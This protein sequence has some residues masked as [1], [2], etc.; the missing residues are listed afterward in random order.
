MNSF[1]HLSNNLGQAQVAQNVDYAITQ[2]IVW[3]VLS[4]LIWWIVIYL[5]DSI[6]QPWKYLEQPGPE[7]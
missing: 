4:T 2:W 6:I 7:Q 3:F 1:I 5:V